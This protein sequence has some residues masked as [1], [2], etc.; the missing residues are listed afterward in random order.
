MTTDGANAVG[1]GDIFVGGALPF[2][3]AKVGLDTYELNVSFSTINGGWT[4]KG[5]V[6]GVSMMHESGTGGAPKYGV[7]SQMPLVGTLSDEG[8]GGAINI[9]D[10]RTYWQPRV[11]DDVARVGY[12][13]TQLESGVGV[14]LSGARHAGIMRYAFPAGD[15]ER[16][17]LVD[18]S[19]Y[20]PQETGG[21]GSQAYLGGEINLDG[22]AYRGHATYEGGWND[23]AP[24]TIYFC[25]E[26]DTAPD[27][28]KTFRGRNTEPI[29]SRHVFSNGVVGQAVFSHNAFGSNDTAARTASSGPMN[30]RVGAVFSWRAEA[31]VLTSR[32]GISFIS[33][34]KACKFKDEE[35]PTWNLNNTVDAAVVEWNRDVFS[36]IRVATDGDSVNRT[37]LVLLYSSLYF[38]H[39]M[40]SD[41]TGE[42][43]LWDSGEPSW[44]D[45]YTLW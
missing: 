35:I 41:R 20:L 2:G 8:G 45:F 12:F 39:L 10:N 30:D 3:V 5:L 32:V 37:N 42:N 43:P 1:G 13:R 23:G 24:F 19:H 31:R 25:G 7:V 28:A 18:L 38:M 33:A 36:K 16:H 22:A 44:D 29:A 6:T 27:E 17:V 15:E 11:G 40:P 4:P 14:E 26:F 21:Y 34:S 9:L